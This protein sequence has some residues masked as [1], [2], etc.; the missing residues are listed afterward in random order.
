MGLVCE[1]VALVA[2]RPV[3]DFHFRAP[4]CLEPR[5]PDPSGHCEVFTDDLELAIDTTPSL[6][7]HPIWLGDDQ[8]WHGADNAIASWLGQHFNLRVDGRPWP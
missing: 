8:E 7:D 4:T 1:V 6:E 2:A 3:H 5:N